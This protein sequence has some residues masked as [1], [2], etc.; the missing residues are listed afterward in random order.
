MRANPVLDVPDAPGRSRTFAHQIIQSEAITALIWIGALALMVALLHQRY[1]AAVGTHPLQQGNQVDF[2]TFLRAGE[3]V[4]AGGSPFTGAYHY[5]YFAP[6][7]LSMS[8]FTHVNPLSILKGW[9]VL[10]LTAF[11]ASVAVLTH[12]LRSCFSHR[13]Q[14]PAFFGICVFTGLHL[15]PMVYEF[16]LSNDDIVVL[17]FLILAA[18]LWQQDRP[19]WFGALV[20]AACLIKVW[21]ILV[22]LAVFEIGVEARR[23]ILAAAALGV[24]VVVGLATN[25]IPAG[26]REFGSFF[27]VVFD[28][29]SQRVE[30]D[31]ITGI[32]RI[33]FSSSG[34]ARPILVSN[35]ARILLTAVLGIWTVGLLLLCLR[36]RTDPMLCVFQ[37]LLFTVL[38]I[39][40]SHMCYSIL[41]LPLLWYWIAHYRVF[42]ETQPREPWHVAMKVV[43]AASLLVWYVIQSRAW[44]EDGYPASISAVKFSY[45]FAAN[46]FLYSSSV[47]GGWILMS[48]NGTQLT[49]PPQHEDR[50]VRVR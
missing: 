44:P 26:I 45:V 6:L 29:R 27:G 20:G 40:V 10:E 12:A 11:M 37:T 50:L 39:P 28:S 34:L 42:I 8:P 43:L 19:I 18:V 49:V 16:F 15:W 3:S 23:R 17:L 30:S 2:R 48:R 9:T 31:S 21:P 38:V 24:T 4:A 32:P 41:A 5:V 13:W 33:F 36:S 14:V 46:L 25:L 35:D 1:I 7:A 22:F 47:F